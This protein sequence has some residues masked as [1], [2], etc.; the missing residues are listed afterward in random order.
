MRIFTFMTILTRICLLLT[1]AAGILFLLA[2]PA[3]AKDFKADYDVEYTLN[4]DAGLM[5]VTQHVSLTNQVANLR[6]SSYSLTLENNSYKNVSARDS[7]GTMKFSQAK[8][9]QGS[10]VLTFTFN[11]RVVGIGNKLKWTIEYD[12]PTLAQHHGQTWDITIPR[13]KEHPSYDIGSYT[14]NLIIPKSAGP[15]AFISPAAPKDNSTNSQYRYAFTK[16]QVLPTGIVA[17]F[18]QAQLFEFTLKYHLHNPNLG[19]AS[20]EIALPPDIPGYQ[21]IIYDKLSPQPVNLRIDDDGNALATYYLSSHANMDVTFTGWAKTIAKHPDL[22]NKG[23]AKELPKELVSTYTKEQPFWQI[24]DPAIVKKTLEITDPQKPVVENAR[25]I[26]NYVTSTL[27]YNTARINKDLKRLGAS[28]AFANP[29]NAVCMEF[30]DVFI[31]MARIAGIPAREVDGYAYT[32]DSANHPI[33]YPGLGSDILHAWAEI[34]LPGSGWVMVDPTWGS[35]TGGVDFFG[36]LDL[37]RIAFAV[38][39]RSSTTPYAA[40]S[41]KT[42]V[43]QDGDVQV[44]FSEKMVTPQLGLNMQLA[45][46]QII[47]GIGSTIPLTFKNKGS[48]TLYNVQLSPTIRLP[49]QL[50]RRIEIP[51]MLLPGQESTVWLPLRTSNWLTSLSTSMSVKADAKDV[52]NTTTSTQ[53]QYTLSVQPFF[54]AIVV[55]VLV[56]IMIV[57]AALGGGWLGLHRLYH[58]T[59]PVGPDDKK[60]ASPS[61]SFVP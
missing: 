32:S 27:Q 34:Y 20:T 3:L 47:A 39:G 40:G 37:N 58:R 50:S 57:A 11:D 13:V 12:S 60:A 21:Q 14:V 16:E 19:Q 54:A 46:R 29:K 24:S 45:D 38:K 42:D 52:A 10:P 33:F 31:T 49:L 55:P 36:R 61:D 23:L 41:Y 4:P 25:A 8:N 56:L 22:A 35:T 15:P 30:T 18:G 2:S 9:D 59:N 43:K 17:T 1:V 7:G 44:S 5:H 6:A 26:Y 51:S 28:E 53:A 48:V